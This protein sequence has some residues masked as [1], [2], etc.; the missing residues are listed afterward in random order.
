MIT[1]SISIGV[2]VKPLPH[3]RFVAAFTTIPIEIMIQYAQKLIKKVISASGITISLHKNIQWWKL[4]RKIQYRQSLNKV[5]INL[6]VIHFLSSNSCLSR[7]LPCFLSELQTSL[8]SFA[9]TYSRY[10]KYNKPFYNLQAKMLYFCG[11]YVTVQPWLKKRRHHAC[12]NG[13]V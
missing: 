1:F 13:F 4:I 5:R 9:I 11:F 2:F 3:L 10:T 8:V 6:K 12:M 7:I